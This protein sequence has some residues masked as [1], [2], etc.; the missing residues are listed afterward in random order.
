MAYR[1]ILISMIEK[2]IS[3]NAEEV[4]HKMKQRL[5][6]FNTYWLKAI[7]FDNGKEFAYDYKIIKDLNVITYF[8]I[9]SPHRTKEL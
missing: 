2:L 8:T 5:T 3:I 9:P 1:K 4:Y 6:N 7:T